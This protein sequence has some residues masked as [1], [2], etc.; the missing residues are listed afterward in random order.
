MHCLSVYWK[1]I[2]HH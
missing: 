2:V 1:F